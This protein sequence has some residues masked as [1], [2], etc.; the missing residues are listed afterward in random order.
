[1]IDEL[2]ETIRTL[3]NASAL[4]GSLLKGAKVSFDLPDAAW[5]G[6]LADLT[7]NCYLYDIRENR[8]MRTAEPLRVTSVDKQ[9]RARVAPP[10][11]I[12]CAY[13]ITAWSTAG[14]EA[15]REEHRLLSEV[16][17]VLLKN[18]TIPRSALQG[19]LSRQIPP[20]PTVIASQ[21]GVKNQPDFW[22]ALDQK[23]KPSLN[24]VV[25]LAMMLEDIDEAMTTA[26]QD[27]RVRVHQQEAKADQK[28]LTR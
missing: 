24:Y 10:V 22:S 20:Y 1:M 28:Q 26:V 9:R 25:T 13:C 4:A 16:L 8:E 3:L 14:T 6:S 15:V 27:F 11:R 2:D 23:L 19:S 18:P 12:D 17:F 21:D 7:V 5:R